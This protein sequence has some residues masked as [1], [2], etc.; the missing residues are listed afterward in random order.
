MKMINSVEELFEGV[1][2]CFDVNPQDVRMRCRKRDR[3]MVRHLYCWVGNNYYKRVFSLKTLGMEIGG[4]DHTT[5][6]NGRDRINS[7]LDTKDE[8]VVRDVQKLKDYFEI[9]EFSIVDNTDLIQENEVL[10]RFNKKYKVEAVKLNHEI[11]AL[12]LEIR[13]LNKKINILEKEMV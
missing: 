1:C 3:V 9:G 7:L 8:I 10:K 12:K 6:I 13:K 5:V 2:D 4:R 11:I